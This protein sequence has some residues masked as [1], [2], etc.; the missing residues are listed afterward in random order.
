M[1]E[2]LINYVYDNLDLDEVQFTF[3]NMCIERSNLMNTNSKLY[4]KISDLV[5]D[6]I[7][8]NELTEKWFEETFFDIEDVFEYIINK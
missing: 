3:G 8:D 2:K 5:D 7:S 6:F 4:Y 1:K